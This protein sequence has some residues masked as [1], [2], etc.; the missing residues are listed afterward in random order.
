MNDEKMEG[1][2]CYFSKR[3]RS[4]VHIANISYANDS[5][6]VSSA[7]RFA[8]PVHGDAHLRSDSYWTQHLFLF[9]A[10]Q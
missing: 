7:V 1:L 2:N 4:I 10:T 8:R 6:V 9:H 3:L 5:I